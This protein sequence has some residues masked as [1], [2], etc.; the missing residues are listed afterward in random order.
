[1]AASIL[2]RSGGGPRDRLPIAVLAAVP[3]AAF[4]VPALLGHLV[5]PGDDL[6]QNFPTRA[7]VGSLIRHGHSPVSDPYIWS[8][9]PLLGGWNAGAAYP[10]T[11]LF[12]VLP[13]GAA[14][15]ANLV[16]TWWVAGIGCYAFLRASRVSPLAAFL[17]AFSFV[18]GGAMTAQLSH[19]GLVAGMSWVPFQLLA[20][21][22]LSQPSGR[23]RLSA[24]LV[25]GVL[26]ALTV[27]AGEP[28]AIADAAVV[29]VIFTLWRVVRSPI[30]WRSWSPYSRLASWPGS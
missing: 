27:L 12:A 15:T 28:R 2:R 9:A 18:F 14:W 13:A 30:G 4:V 23:R 24:S 20:L 22:R 19:F 7:L 25:F 10:L 6:L 3:V 17:G 1:M 26:L 29:L 8:G 16:V 5:I 21:L 11:W